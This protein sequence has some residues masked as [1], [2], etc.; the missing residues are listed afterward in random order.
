VS[1]LKLDYACRSEA[2]DKPENADAAALRL[3][4]GEAVAYLG[5]SGLVE[6]ALRG[7][8]LREKLRLLEGAAVDLHG[9]EEEP[10]PLAID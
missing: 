3:P 10:P 4:E 5:S 8:S 7:G 6:I 1:E 9:P 2:G